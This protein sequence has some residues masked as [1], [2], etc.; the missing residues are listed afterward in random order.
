MA[1]LATRTAKALV[2]L[3]PLAAGLLALAAAWRVSRG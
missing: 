1:G 2:V 3:I